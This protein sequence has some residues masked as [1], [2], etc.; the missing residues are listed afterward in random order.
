MQGRDRRKDSRMQ[1]HLGFVV[2]V[3]LASLSAWAAPTD[4]DALY[5]AKVFVTGQ[6]EETRA[7]ALAEALSQVLV[8]VSGDPSVVHDRRLA[9]IDAAALAASLDY[10][11]RMAGIS[12]HDEQG[13][14]ERPFD[15]TVTFRRSGIDAALAA[16]GRKPWT[17]R[18]TFVAL[19]GVDNGARQFVLTRDGEFGRDM[20]EAIAEAG[21]RFGLTLS[22]PYD[23]GVAGTTYS[24]LAEPTAAN[25]VSFARRAGA[26]VALAGTLV[27]SEAARGW[28]AEWRLDAGGRRYRWT[29]SGVSFDRAFRTGAGGAAQALSGNGA[30]E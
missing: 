12:V 17:T 1:L 15:L 22:L 28:Q 20:R 7:P 18:P 27:W 10:R 11:D 6:G 30:P 9:G 21:E 25:L 26:D 24:T 13:T 2:A 23:A 19:L 16:L 4:V 8:K 5:R 29:V 3:V 14:R